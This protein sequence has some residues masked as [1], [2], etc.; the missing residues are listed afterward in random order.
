VVDN[1]DSD[2]VDATSEEEKK[3]ISKDDMYRF[4]ADSSRISNSADKV[5]LLF[6][7]DNNNNVDKDASANGEGILTC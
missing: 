3:T 4:L 7:N 2:M 1:D 5:H 6:L